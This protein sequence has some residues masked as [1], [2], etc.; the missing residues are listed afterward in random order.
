MPSTQHSSRTSCVIS[1]S[2]KKGINIIDYNQVF[3]IKRK[4]NGSLGR[5][6]ACLVAKGFNQ[7]Y[8]IDYEY[9]FSPVIEPTTTRV[10]LSI[11]ISRGWTLWQ[12]DV[13][14]DFLYVILEE[15]VYMNQPARYEDSK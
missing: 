8:G 4:H 11:V 13:Q 7:W 14:I 10:V 5:Y 1:Y 2:F 12:L 6:K 3:K 15:E 9:T